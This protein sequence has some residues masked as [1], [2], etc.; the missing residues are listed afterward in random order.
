MIYTH[1]V[2]HGARGFGARPIDCGEGERSDGCDGFPITAEFLS[3]MNRF[4]F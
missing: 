2:E 4:W 3:E 1:V